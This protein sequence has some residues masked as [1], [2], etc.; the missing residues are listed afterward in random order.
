MFR[1]SI[2]ILYGIHN[3]LELTIKEDEIFCHY[4]SSSSTQ[5]QLKVIGLP[6]E[7]SEMLKGQPDHL[8]TRVCF[9]CCSSGRCNGVSK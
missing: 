2:I 9:T 3:L 1:F 5:S 8:E 4:S 6:F 7:F